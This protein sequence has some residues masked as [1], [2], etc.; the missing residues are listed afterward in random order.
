MNQL[1]G[2]L[3]GSQFRAVRSSSACLLQGPRKTI[4][5]WLKEWYFII[6]YIPSGNN[7]HSYGCMENGPFIDDLL[8]KNC[9]VGGFNQSEKYQSVGIILPNI[10]KNKIHVPNHQLSGQREVSKS[11]GPQKH[12]KSVIQ[13][14]IDSFRVPNFWETPKSS[15]W[16]WCVS[17]AQPNSKKTVGP[18]AESTRNRFALDPSVL[19]VAHTNPKYRL[20][21]WYSLVIFVG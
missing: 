10:W 14:E 15:P 16:W 1:W 7:S 19:S 21:H 6:L 5:Q 2:T 18:S 12:P 9:L 20:Y 17:F 4:T 8:I 13:R 3:F 11:L